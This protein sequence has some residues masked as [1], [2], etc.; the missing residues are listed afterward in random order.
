[1]AA[2]LGIEFLETTAEH[3]VVR[4][5][6][7]P[8]HHNHVGGPHAGAVFTLTETAAGGAVVLAA[9][10]DRLSQAVPLA[11]RAETGYRKPAMGP[12]TTT[13]RLGRPRRRSSP[14][15]AGA[16]ARSSP[17]PSPSGARSAP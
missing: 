7:R 14:N 9:C 16:S 5:P 4:L 8:A 3:A 12:V 2:T 1:M 6:D 10:A 13:A 11:V 17:S 15:S